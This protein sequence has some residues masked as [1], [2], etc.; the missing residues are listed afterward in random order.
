M[1]VSEILKVKGDI[2]YTVTPDTSMLD[3]VHTMAEKDIGSLVVMEFGTLVGMLSFREVMKTMDRNNGSVGADTVRKH[4]DDHPITITPDTEV[5]E[6]RRIMLE[7][8]ARYVPIMD[9]KTVHGVI[10]FYDVAR[11]VLEAQSFENKMLKAYI[12]DWPAEGDE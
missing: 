4:M 1:K 12:R 3:A 2:L 6:V 10:S 8:H 7:K 11:A 9:A 5:N